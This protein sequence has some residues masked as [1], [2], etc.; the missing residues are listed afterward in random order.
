MYKKEEF[1]PS[2]TPAPKAD[3]IKGSKKNSA[4]SAKSSS[5]ASKISLGKNTNSILR[6]KLKAFREKYPN[7]T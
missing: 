6:E 5:S 2:K 7:K 3:R 4:G 1:A